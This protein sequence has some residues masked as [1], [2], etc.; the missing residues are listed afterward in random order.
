M[1]RLRGKLTALSGQI[2]EGEMIS[3]ADSF[4][5]TDPV[6]GSVTENQGLRIFFE[7]GSRIV[8]RLSGTGTVGATLRLYIE[9]YEAMDG[10]HNFDVATATELLADIANHITDLKATLGR[11][12]PTVIS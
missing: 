10:N 8:F 4:A 3:K 1:E 11:G 2:I 6:D 12:A 7:S 5:Y 9:R